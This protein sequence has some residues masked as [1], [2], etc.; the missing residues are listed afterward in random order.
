M[1]TPVFLLD[2][3]VKSVALVAIGLMYLRHRRKWVEIERTLRRLGQVLERDAKKDVPTISLNQLRTRT[4]P[5]RDDFS[6]N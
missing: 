5:T 2:L 3:A 1:S 4:H 6:L